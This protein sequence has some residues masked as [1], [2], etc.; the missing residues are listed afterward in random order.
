MFRSDV[1]TALGVQEAWSL[2]NDSL[3]IPLCVRFR[4]L[5]IACACVFL[6]ARRLSIAMPEDPPWWEFAGATFQDLI[7]VC[8]E[9]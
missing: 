5:T 7:T 6:A 4:S 1:P 2:A 8:Q 9:I 3:Q